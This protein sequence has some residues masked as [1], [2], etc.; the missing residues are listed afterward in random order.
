MQETSEKDKMLRPSYKLWFETRKGYA[1]GKG[2]FRLLQKIQEAGTLSDAAKELG[3]SYRYAWGIIKRTEKRIGK[4]IVKT[5]KGGKRGGGAEL[6]QVGRELLNEFLKYKRVFDNVYLDESSWEGLHLKISARN[7]IRGRITSIE[8]G[9]VAAVV[10]IEIET[11]CT[12]TSFIT[13][14]AVEDLNIKEGDIVK[15]VIKSTEVMI[16]KDKE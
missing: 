8:K 16:S 10:K 6:T 5:H 1:F 15:A 11:P 13:R 3:M 12:I 14:E 7:R 9:D 2:T 4:A